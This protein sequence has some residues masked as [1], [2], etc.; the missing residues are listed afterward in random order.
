MARDIGLL[1]PA[2]RLLSNPGFFQDRPDHPSRSSLSGLTFGIPVQLEDI[3]CEPAILLGLETAAGAIRSL[4]GNITKTDHTDWRPG[5][6]RR[7]GLLV[8]EAEGA[9]QLSDLIDTPNAISDGL[10]AMLNYGRTA[11]AEKI[12]AARAEIAAAA[13][14]V[15]AAFQTVDAVLM[16]TSPQRAFAHGAPIPANQ[17]DLTALANF[18]GCPAVALPVALPGEVLPASVQ[19]LAPRRA[20]F[21][22]LSWAE[23][24]A[25][26]LDQTAPAT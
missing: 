18:S 13:Q 21:Q 7:A 8:T 3:D 11:P 20:D 2:L 6:A 14:S 26:E 22:L 23:T 1:A 5:K 25:A 12:A 19:M 9:I 24:L 15:E 16:P 10:R 4:G 17:A